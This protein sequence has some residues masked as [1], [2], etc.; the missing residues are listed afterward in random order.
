MKLIAT[1]EIEIQRSRE[2]VFN[3][4]VA[5]TTYPRILHAKWP[6]PGIALAELPEG[7]ELAAGVRRLVTLT[8]GTV[9]DEEILEFE[10]PRVHRYA[11]SKGLRCP[12][13]LMVRRA[14]SPR[15]FYEV[16]DGAKVEWT[17]A[18][19]VTNVLCYPAVK[20]L[21]MRFGS[22]MRAGLMRA[23]SAL[24]S[25]TGDQLGPGDDRPD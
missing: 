19:E 23:K 25:A 7:D 1:A 13:S 10:R 16:G 5:C 8:D 6:V 22:W 2:I 9:I 14:K 4:L 18:F 20:P 11:W 3:T 15:H 24:E 12:F 17:Y 21:S